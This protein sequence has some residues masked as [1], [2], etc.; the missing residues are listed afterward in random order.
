MRPG[1]QP[2][3]LHGEREHTLE[4][5]KLTIGSPNKAARKASH[6][7]QLARSLNHCPNSAGSCIAS[8]MVIGLSLPPQ[9]TTSEDRAKTAGWRCAGPPTATCTTAALRRRAHCRGGRPRWV[10][11]PSPKRSWSPPPGRPSAGGRGPYMASW[12]AWQSRWACRSASTSAWRWAS[13]S[14]WTQRAGTAA[15]ARSLRT[16]HRAQTFRHHVRTR[17]LRS[18]RCT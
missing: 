7:R 17:P 8:R 1:R 10:R 4:R 5:R 13:V 9:L 14:A 11:R 3:R 12:S 16:L 2:A 15:M 6:A 18:A